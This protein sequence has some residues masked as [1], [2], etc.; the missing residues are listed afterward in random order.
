M[1]DEG[2]CVFCAWTL[3]RRREAEARIAAREWFRK[4]AAKKAAGMPRH[5]RLCI[6]Q[7]MKDRKP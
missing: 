3:A 7:S 1:N 4:E 2:L 5:E 6:E